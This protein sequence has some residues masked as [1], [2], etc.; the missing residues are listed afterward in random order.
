M[1]QMN[2]MTWITL[3]VVLLFIAPGL[4]A[5]NQVGAI[6]DKAGKQ[7]MLSQRIAKNYLYLGQKIQVGTA[8]RQ[9]KQSIDEFKKNH[10]DLK[11]TVNDQEVQ[12][13]LTFVELSLDEYLLTVTQPYDPGSAALVLDMS[14]VILE[15]SQGVVEQLEQASKAK[16]ARAVN[17]AG[18]QRMLSQRIAKFYIA[19]MAGLRDH[20]TV[21]QLQ[22]A[23][24]EFSGA[25]RW[26][27]THEHN[28]RQIQGELRRVAGLWNTIKRYYMDV[29]RK[30][31][32][33]IV[34]VT[35]DKIME[36]MNRVTG[37]YVKLAA[38]RKL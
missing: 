38:A 31:L 5:A 2:R 18:R 33:A 23:V 7:R 15:G 17:V 24:E 34:Y 4:A 21:Q 12:D 8:V 29:N 10:Q 32:P 14:E 20:N 27:S 28:T 11:V 25:L 9:L 22:K 35:T 16:A 1:R 30:S 37:M 13:L 26:L 3:L 36:S 6:I 19:H